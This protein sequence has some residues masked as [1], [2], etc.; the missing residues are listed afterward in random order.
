[1]VNAGI[2]FVDDILEH[3]GEVEVVA[4]EERGVPGDVLS[5]LPEDSA[6]C[7]LGCAGAQNLGAAEPH[8]GDAVV[9][10]ASALGAEIEDH[11]GPGCG[12]I[13]RRGVVGGEGRGVH[14]VRE[15]VLEDLLGA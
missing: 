4:R 12:A 11:V 7:G 2:D 6:L 5:N 10:L 14:G 15:G 8:A 13:E 3:H 1:V 9:L